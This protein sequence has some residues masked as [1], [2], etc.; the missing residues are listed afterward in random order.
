MNVIISK[1][2]SWSEN[3]FKLVSDKSDQFIWMSEINTEVLDSLKPQWIFFFHWSDIV[4]AEI[5]TKYKCVVIHT[6]NLPSGRGGSPIQNQILDGI[7]TTKVNL[8]EMG[9]VIDGG[10]V[11]TSH[12]ITLQGNL[13]DIWFMI[14][15]VSATLILNC[16][17]N[18]LD[19]L[20]Q[21]GETGLYKRKKNNKIIFDKSKDISYIYDQIRMLDAEDYPN[22]Y[23]EVDGYTLEFSRAKLQNKTIIADVK[24]TKK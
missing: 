8:I 11:Y 18:C 19:P 10:G 9:P 7:V 12:E 23:L 13:T 16:V 5:Y 2:N 20:P 22:V 1:N 21:I 17:N 3:L 24:I 6:G 4:D 14:A 15:N